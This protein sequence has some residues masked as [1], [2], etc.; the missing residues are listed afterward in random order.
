MGGNVDSAVQNGTG[1]KPFRPN[2]EM[3]GARMKFFVAGSKEL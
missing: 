1:S 2:A 3:D